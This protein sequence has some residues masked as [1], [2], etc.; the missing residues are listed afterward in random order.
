MRILIAILL[1]LLI[2]LQYDLWVGE[3][4]LATVWRLHKAVD[5]QQAENA[6]LKERNIALEAEVNDL[7]TGNEAIE[8]RARNELDMV[9]KGETYIQ[10]IEAEQPRERGASAGE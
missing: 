2:V 4:S 7:K 8:E 5:T 6:G 10:V 9:K 3:G 1:V